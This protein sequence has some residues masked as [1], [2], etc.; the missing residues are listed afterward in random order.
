MKK[1]T[2]LRCMSCKVAFKRWLPPSF[3]NKSGRYYC[4]IKC[5][6]GRTG[7]FNANWKGTAITRIC[8][9]CGNLFSNY[10]KRDIVKCCSIECRNKSFEKT[11]NPEEALIV[12]KELRESPLTLSEF[13]K[14]KG[15]H[16][17]HFS[18]LLKLLQ[19]AEYEEAMEHKRLTWDQIYR[20]GRLF[21]FEVRKD[22]IKHGYIVMISPRSLGP[23]DLMAA[24]SGRLLLVQCKLHGKLLPKDRK[25]L[26]AASNKAGGLS[27]FAKKF[28]DI[29]IY[30]T[31]VLNEREDKPDRYKI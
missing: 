25:S 17:K 7:I 3:R 21:E 31:V 4:S 15:M 18:K 1:L 11:L 29:I 27:I 2:A 23:A 24:K 12:I 8:I 22:L 28:N 9:I 13:S 6:S 26:R 19:P 14:T 30:E 20:A 10:D 16:Y 5:L